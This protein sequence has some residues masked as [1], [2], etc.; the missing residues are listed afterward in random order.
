[1]K[2]SLDKH[3]NTGPILVTGTGVGVKNSK[4]FYERYMDATLS[5]YGEQMYL[6]TSLIPPQTPKLILAPDCTCHCR[7]CEWS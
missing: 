2:T 6:K 1:M 7:S 4:V 3:H 5:L